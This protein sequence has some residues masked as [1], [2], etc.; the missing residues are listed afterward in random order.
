MGDEHL[1][2]IPE[3]KSDEFI[4]SSVE[5]LVPSP[6]ESKDISDGECDLPLCDDFP[7]SHL[8]TFSNPL[9]NIDN[10]F[11]MSDD[12]SFSK[13]DVPM[14]NFKIFYNP[15]FD[16]D[17]E[18]I[19]TKVNSI[20]N[21]VL[22]SITS[23]PLGIDYFDAESN[24]IESLLNRNTSIDSTSKIDS[25]LDEFAYELIF[26]KSIPSRIN[27]ADFDLEGDISLI[28]RLLYVENYIESFSPSPIPIKDSDSL[29]EE[30]DLFLTPDNSMP[31]G[32]EN[33]DYASE[34]DIL[35]LE[36]FLS[37]DS[38]SLPENESFHFDVPSSPRPPAKPP[39]VRIYLEPNTGLLT[40]KEVDISKRY[41]HVPIVLPTQ[42]TLC[43]V[44]DTLIPFSSKNKDKVH[45]ISHR[46]FKDFQLISDSLVMIYR[47]NIPT[48]E[49]LFLHFY[50][51]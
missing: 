7:K 51:P 34:G 28:E 1:D 14:E 37:N 9:F 17:E 8:V 42:P 12:E 43:P 36:E 6:S 30:I 16:L 48:L 45:L 13:E 15:L 25:L 41:V 5:N 46:G 22:E 32:I 50:P 35:F 20:Q 26:L 21:E 38:H 47:G 10:D 33:D 49:V 24:L 44:T 19:F 27:E 29:R 31:P 11:T 2:T 23:I 40:A 39:N 4:K 3:M 18:I